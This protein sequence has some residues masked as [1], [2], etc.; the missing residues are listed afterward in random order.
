MASLPDQRAQ[1]KLHRYGP[2]EP[3]QRVGGRQSGHAARVI[4]ITPR[5][6][7]MA[8]LENFSKAGAGD[9]K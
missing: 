2:E 8:G 7:I 4:A 3:R 1:P 6:G 5:T 9:A